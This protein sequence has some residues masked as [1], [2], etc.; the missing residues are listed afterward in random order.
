MKVAIFSRL[1]QVD[2]ETGVPPK[3]RPTLFRRVG[4]FLK[5]RWMGSG[6]FRKIHIGCCVGCYDA[7]W[8]PRTTWPGRARGA[9][10]R[11]DPSRELF[12]PVR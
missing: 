8:R 5:I 4:A 3:R 7:L 11:R 10:R 1:V 2:S 12:L 6:S 9:A